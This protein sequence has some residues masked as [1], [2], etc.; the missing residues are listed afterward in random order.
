[1]EINW[2][3]N[4]ASIARPESFV[5]KHAPLGAPMVVAAVMY[6]N[7]IYRTVFLRSLRYLDIPKTPLKTERGAKRRVRKY[8]ELWALGGYQRTYL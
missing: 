3:D 4:V 2:A 8:I 1:M 7:G 5:A 6:G